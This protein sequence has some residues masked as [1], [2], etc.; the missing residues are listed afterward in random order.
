MAEPAVL[1][2]AGEDRRLPQLIL[3]VTSPADSSL[4]KPLA[5]LD[6]IN[7]TVARGPKAEQHMANRRC[8]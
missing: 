4:S 2:E 6:R 8:P 1:T 7:N 3:I 5:E